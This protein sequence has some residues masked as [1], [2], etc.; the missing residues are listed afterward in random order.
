MLKKLF[1]PGDD[2]CLTSA[3]L[4][5]LRLWL[6]LTML[7]NHGLGKLT[8]FSTLAAKFGDPLGIG[9]SASLALAVF[10]EFFASILLVLGLVTRFAALVLAVNMTVA[11]FI[12]HKG[13]LSGS[14]SGE[15]AF[16]YLGG[17]VML[18]LA[19]AGRISLDK[20]L[21]GGGGKA[22]APPAKQGAV[23]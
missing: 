4:L 15:L 11:F 3:A 13:A 12:A 20:S 10:A 18:L 21:F 2:S 1:A 14:H 9:P 22:G 16:I 7:L 23:R 6:G 8:G 5:T 19:G 17:Y